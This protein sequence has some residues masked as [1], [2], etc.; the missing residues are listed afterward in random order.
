MDLE[1]TIHRIYRFSASHRLHSAHLSEAENA[2]LYGKCNNPFGH[3][4]DYV[5]DV[6][7][8]G[9]LDVDSGLIV[10]ITNLDGLVG[11]RVLNAF[12]HRNL[13]EDVREFASIVPT[14]ENV[15]KVIAE[16]LR[17]GWREYFPYSLAR[18][19]SI[20]IQETERNSVEVVVPCVT[21][22]DRQAAEK[23]FESVILNA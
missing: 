8:S 1:T 4:H 7:V 10:S 2:R 16:R 20:S 21:D 22:R 13:N 5:L 15:A 14:T 12:S 19:S 9:T 17:D 11:S 3:G 18:L 23:N 6:A